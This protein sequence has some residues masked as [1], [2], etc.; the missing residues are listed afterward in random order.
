MTDIRTERLRA[1][2]AAM[3]AGDFEAAAA[4]LHKDAEWID[5]P[6]FVGSGRHVGR[7]AI[8]AFWESY[9]EAFSEWRMEMHSVE[10]LDDRRSL[11]TVRMIQTGRESGI[12]MQFDLFQV[13]T[14]DGD[15]AI[16]VKSSTNL[17]QAQFS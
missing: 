7:E 2:F 17:D 14:F 9:A 11:V 10:H 12:S 13:W 6:D 1:G 16:R 15:E 5:P 4:P 3:N 8:V